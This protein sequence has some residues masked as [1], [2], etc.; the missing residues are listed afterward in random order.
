MFDKAPSARG[1]SLEMARKI[2]ADAQVAAGFSLKGQLEVLA[3]ARDMR[4]AALMSDD[5]K[6]FLA[7]LERDLNLPVD[8]FLSMFS[9]H[10]LVAVLSPSGQQSWSDGAYLA[11][12]LDEPERF[13]KW[14]D[15]QMDQRGQEHR[16]GDFRVRELAGAFYG[17]KADWFFIAG[18]ATT[19]RRAAEGLSGQGPLLADHPTFL[20]AERSLTGGASGAF[21]YVE[22]TGAREN[23]FTL[24]GL[25]PDHPATD[26]LAFWDF[27]IL[28]FDFVKQ[29]GD[30]FLGFNPDAGKLLTALRRPGSVD[31]RLVDLVP[32]DMSTLNAVDAAW[33]AG[34]LT[35]FG[36][37]VADVGVLLMMAGGELS[38]YGDFG[39]AFEGKLAVG[40]NVVEVLR[41]AMRQD[42][43]V[44]PPDQ[45]GHSDKPVTP[46]QLEEPSMLVVVPVKSVAAAHEIMVNAVEANETSDADQCGRYLTNIGA[47]LMLWSED[48][49]ATY[50]E[51]LRQLVPDYLDEVPEC[52]AARADTYSQG[53]RVDKGTVDGASDEG[54]I[55]FCSGHHHPELQADK[56]SFQAEGGLDMGAVDE[57]K[58]ARR[59]TA[60]P[61]DGEKSSYTVEHGP[62]AVLDDQSKVLRL[63]YGPLARSYLQSGGGMASRPQVAEALKWG[64]GSIIYL[65]YLDFEPLADAFEEA[66][67]QASAAGEEEAA[68]FE[69]MV[70]ALRPRLGPLRGTSCVKVT[71]QGLHLRTDGLGSGAMVMVVALGFTVTMPIPGPGL[72]EDQ[73]PPGGPESEAEMP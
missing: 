61:Q 73:V 4:R 30:G 46:D 38:K 12:R 44:A 51:S 15:G 11:L 54:F 28:S 63:A 67:R 2:P 1:S 25:S 14:L 6:G 41:A 52:P 33:G 18:D 8:R 19:A 23:L 7:A 68:A 45:D 58:L 72:P 27:A 39:S 71:E 24:I 20:R 62:T 56:P 40:S 5:S 9:G 35:Q 17:L 31:A 10:G 60:L 66:C 59:R 65:D 47:S 50:P 43:Y 55:L 34:V 37:D 49:S 42:L 70:S 16:M 53:Y 69:V 64:Q 48:H 26:E 3:M 57:S 22:G 21:A 36:A 29:R 13:R 32:P